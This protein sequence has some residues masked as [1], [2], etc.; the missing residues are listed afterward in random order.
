M[1]Y[2]LNWIISFFNGRLKEKTTWVGI[3]SLVVIGLQQL[4]IDPCGGEQTS[5]AGFGEW[6]PIVISILSGGAIVLPSKV[7]GAK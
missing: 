2:I 5:T 6:L 7:M 1:I 4:G 3:T